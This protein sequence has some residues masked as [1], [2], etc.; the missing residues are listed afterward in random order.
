MFLHDCYLTLGRN[1]GQA[2]AL[3]DQTV[4]LGLLVLAVPLGLRALRLG[5]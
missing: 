5:F 3:A 4:Q 1:G 2:A